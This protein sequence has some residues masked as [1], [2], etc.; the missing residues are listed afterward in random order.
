MASNSLLLRGWH[1]IATCG[2]RKAI[3]VGLVCLYVVAGVVKGCG[4]ESQIRAYQITELAPMMFPKN[5]I[6][7]NRAKNIEWAANFDALKDRRWYGFSSC[8][9]NPAGLIQAGNDSRVG[10]PIFF[11]NGL[12]VGSPIHNSFNFYGRSLSSIIKG[13]LDYIRCICFWQQISHV[14]N[15]NPCPLVKYASLFRFIQLP[16]G[17]HLAGLK[18]AFHRLAF[19]VENLQFAEVNPA[20]NA[21]PN[22]SEK[23]EN[24]GEL[25]NPIWNMGK[26][27]IAAA[28]VSIGY[29]W[30]NVRWKCRF[31][32]YRW[33]DAVFGLIS[34]IIGFILLFCSLNASW[35]G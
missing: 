2:Y 5:I 32:N 35:I 4:T 7:P 10:N 27:G 20:I 11:W 13:S 1:E 6:I 28:L 33:I 24:E 31:N 8:E 22:N 34:I 3:L 16:L 25:F 30:W 17:D 15:R 19:T 29:G 23:F 18:F 26:I 14:R 9:L 21:K 12:H